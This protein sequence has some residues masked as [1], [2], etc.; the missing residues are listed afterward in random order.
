MAI[1]YGVLQQGYLILVN[2]AIIFWA[3]VFPFHYRK[4]IV[5]GRTRYVHIAVVIT[6]LFLPLPFALVHLKDGFIG[7]ANPVNACVGRN[8]NFNYY[9]FTLPQSILLCAATILLLL[10]GR[11]IFKVANKSRKCFAHGHS[12][13]PKCGH[14]PYYNNSVF[15]LPIY[16]FLVKD[17]NLFFSALAELVSGDSFHGNACEVSLCLFS[18]Q[19]QRLRVTKFITLKIFFSFTADFVVEEKCTA[20]WWSKSWAQDIFNPHIYPDS[21]SNGAGYLLI[22][23]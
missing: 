13:T 3:L 4:L 16:I 1:S 18:L 17:E 10:V 7:A 19:W 5:T 15:C 21:W 9:F 6:A 22:R 12:G 2:A 8:S 23:H 20:C 11:E 14:F